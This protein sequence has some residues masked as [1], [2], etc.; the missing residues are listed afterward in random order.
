MNLESQVC[1]LELA[2]RLKK[3]GIKQESLFFWVTGET[4]DVDD[5]IYPVTTLFYQPPPGAD[6]Y[7]SAFTVAELGEM[8]PHWC[9]SQKIISASNLEETGEWR[10]AAYHAPTESSYIYGFTEANA[11]ARMLIYLI[12]KKI[13]EVPK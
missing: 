3:V 4:Y 7:V 12:E 11:R 5:N 8:L 9:R 1:S 10:C 6:D 2:E 13:I